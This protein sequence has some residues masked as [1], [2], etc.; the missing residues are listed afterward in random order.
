[1]RRRGVRAASPCQGVGSGLAART[2]RQLNERI[3]LA[4]ERVAGEREQRPETPEQLKVTA[5]H[6]VA[7]LE[8]VR[9]A[10]DASEPSLSGQQTTM[11]VGDSPLSVSERPMS[12]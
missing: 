3:E 10:A 5:E 7:L 11:S 9:G 2:V 12:A 6:G 1:V 8:R 4:G